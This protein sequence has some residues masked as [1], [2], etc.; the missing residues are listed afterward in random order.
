MTEKE[1]L[2]EQLQQLNKIT[3]STLGAWKSETLPIISKIFGNES[4]QYKQ[5]ANVGCLSLNGYKDCH[6]ETFKNCLTGFIK[7]LSIKKIQRRHLT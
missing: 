1:L 6:L 4:T 2:E 7:C 3:I 5:F